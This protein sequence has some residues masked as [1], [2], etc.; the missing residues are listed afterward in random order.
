VN[1]ASANVEIDVGERLDPA[2][3]LADPLEGK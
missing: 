3:S 1:F 2:E